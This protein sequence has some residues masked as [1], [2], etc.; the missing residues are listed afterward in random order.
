MFLRFDYMITV[1]LH[2]L[3]CAHTNILH[4]YLFYTRAYSLLAYILSAYATLLHSFS[5]V[6]IPFHLYFCIAPMLLST[7]QKKI[8]IGTNTCRCSYVPHMFVF[9]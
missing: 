6:M 3:P 2:T 5:G 1:V 9:I 4:E 7:S 8:S